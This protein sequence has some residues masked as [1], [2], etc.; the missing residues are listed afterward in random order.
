MV[1]AAAGLAS[2]SL[3]ARAAFAEDE[4]EITGTVANLAGACPELRFT[5]GAQPV[6]SDA[7]TEF[8]DGACPEVRDGERVKVE[9]IVGA[10]G[11]LVATELEL[12]R[13][14]RVAPEPGQ[15]R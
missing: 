6:L 12:E 10:D 11:I 8:D 5:L 1:L 14:D 13:R 9:G 15:Q 2:A 3:P 4:L 7:R